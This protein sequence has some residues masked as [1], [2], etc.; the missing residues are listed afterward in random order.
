MTDLVAL[1]ITVETTGFFWSAC[2]IVLKMSV[3]KNS[4]VVGLIDHFTEIARVKCFS[5]LY[6]GVGCT[7]L[8]HETLAS[9]C[10]EVL[11]PGAKIRHIDS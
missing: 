7:R 10:V 4:V 1:I 5:L 8:M 6:S 3:G 11:T 9:L 2:F